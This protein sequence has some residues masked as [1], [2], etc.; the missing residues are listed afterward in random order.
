MATQNASNINQQGIVYCDGSGAFTGNNLQ[1]ATNT[2]SSTNTNGDIILSPDGTGGVVAVTDLT[3]GNSTQDVSFTVNG[4]AIT[5][6]V[7]VE[8]TNST[9]LGGVISHRHSDTAAFGGHFVNLRSRGT[10]ASPTAVS[11]NDTISIIA[12]AGY[13]GTDYAQSSQIITQ[14]DGTPGA[15]DMPG[16]M[17]FLTSA[18][19]GQTPTEAMRITSGQLVGINTTAPIGT[20]H[21]TGN[22]EL[23]HTAAEND[24]YAI[25]IVCDA[26]GFTDVKAFDIDYIT[27]NIAAGQ[28]EEAIIVNI[29]ENLSTGGIVAGYLVLTT[30][31]GS[32]TVNGYETGIG[33]NPV[34]QESG[35]F[36]DADNILN[37]AADV[38]VAL[39]GG[40]AGNI[41]IFV[42][43]NDTIT[44]GDAAIWDE[45]EI[46]LDTGASGSG[47][48]PTFEY[49]TGGSGFSAFSPADGTNG[50][51]NTGAILWDSSTLSGWATNASGR[52]EVRVTRTRNTLGTTP[53]I[54]KLKISST[55]EYTWDKDGDLSVR[56]L[57]LTNALTVPNGGTGATTFTADAILLGNGTS[58][59]TQ[60]VNTKVDSN[61]NLDANATWAGNT[62]RISIVNNSNSANSAAKLTMLVGGTSAADVYTEMRIGSARSYSVGVDN[63]DS[64]TFKITTDAAATVTPSGGT[65]LMDITSGGEVSFPAATLTENGLMLVG[66]SGLLESLGVATNGQIPIGSTGANPVL[67]T[68]TAGTNISITN[69]AGSITINSGGSGSGQIVNVTALDNTDSPYTVL[70]TDYYM[71]CDTTAGV[72]TVTLPNAPTTGTVYVVKDAAGTADSF[73]ITIGTAGA[74]TIDGAATFVMNTEYEAVNL[75]YNGSSWEIY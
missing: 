22:M 17:L 2:I 1:A 5:A 59:I 50:F 58:A 54:D 42:N 23:D 44:I 24:D 11:D 64:Q 25:E 8:G 35:T 10:H 15:N 9:D 4:S 40:G 6:T 67:S 31:E 62:R 36:G 43:D 26:N 70:S 65:T 39:S 68:I 57:S 69:G 3:V 29:D 37:I 45:M 28:N 71:S 27:G 74:E 66:A 12:S 13:D 53:I 41:S 63:D 21:V 30:T 61:G 48:A 72:L 33:I 19:G 47:V 38:T 14:V 52:Y 49:S 51:R 32:A 73:N 55:T 7:S 34:V 18:D 16:R 75:L 60:Q 20:L 46:I 56:G